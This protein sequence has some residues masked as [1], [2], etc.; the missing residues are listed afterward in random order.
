M[1]ANQIIGHIRRIFRNPTN[2]QVFIGIILLSCLLAVTIG[3]SIYKRAETGIEEVYKQKNSREFSG[4]I[5]VEVW[6][7]SWVRTGVIN[8]IHAR[9]PAQWR[10]AD[11]SK[12]CFSRRFT[13]WN[14]IYQT[15]IQEACADIA[16]VQKTFDSSCLTI[17]KCDIPPEALSELELILDR[18]HAVFSQANF[19]LP[20][21]SDEQNTIE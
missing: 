11:W 6:L 20:Y 4:D 13:D 2:I 18:L 21:E 10:A 5:E 12:G 17:E 1:L 16:E 19:V 7:Y 3:P 14:A 15:A 9:G 8:M